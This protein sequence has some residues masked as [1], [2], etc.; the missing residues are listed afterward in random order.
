MNKAVTALKKLLGLS[1]KLLGLQI[2]RQ[3]HYGRGYHN[4]DNPMEQW[5]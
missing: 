3:F 2:N 1:K 4:K 5:D